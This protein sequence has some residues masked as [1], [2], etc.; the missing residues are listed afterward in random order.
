[1]GKGQLAMISALV[2]LFCLTHGFAA[3][4]DA[5]CVTPDIVGVTGE[6]EGDEE[7][8]Q[9]RR[10]E[11]AKVSHIR[12]ILSERL[13]WVSSGRRARDFEKWASKQGDLKV[14]SMHGVDEADLDFFLGNASGAVNSS[15]GLFADDAINLALV[16]V[17][18][19]P[20][21]YQGKPFHL[22]DGQ[23]SVVNLFFRSIRLGFNFA[24][25]A[26]T[27]WLALVSSTFREKIWFSWIASCL[28]AS[29]PAFIKWGT[30]YALPVF[31]N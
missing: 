29:G 24:P 9:Q 26:S 20:S 13:R 5:I 12:H 4:A 21:Q 19:L 28:A 6:T 1:M 16:P 30:Y 17:R 10:L 2:L 8:E 18:E 3:S 22:E 31:T 15:N 11:V 23:I 14:I 25:V 7:Q 27:A